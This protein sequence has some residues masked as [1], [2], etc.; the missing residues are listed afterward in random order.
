MGYDR[1]LPKDQLAIRSFVEFEEAVDLKFADR[2]Y[3]VVSD[4]FMFCVG[5][6]PPPFD[7]ELFLK[8]E[9]KARCEH[10]GSVQ[11]RAQGFGLQSAFRA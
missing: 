10:A 7:V 2:L 6:T 8:K 3:D 1:S 5:G 4:A 11:K 9:S